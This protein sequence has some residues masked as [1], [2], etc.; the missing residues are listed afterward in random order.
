MFL[1][2][3]DFGKL[4][5]L[6]RVLSGCN[7]SFSLVIGIMRGPNISAALPSCRMVGG[8][9]KQRGDISIRAVCFS[10]HSE[11]CEVKKRST[12]VRGKALYPLRSKNQSQ[13]LDD[14]GF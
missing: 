3:S 10:T 9:S 5:Q 14:D 2:R 1:S 8:F 11:G 6:R 13:E 4:S 7:I 12:T